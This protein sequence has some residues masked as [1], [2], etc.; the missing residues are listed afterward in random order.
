MAEKEEE[1]K[2][3]CPECG[4][5]VGTK[6]V[7]GKTKLKVHKVAGE[8]CEGSDTEVES[9]DTAPEGLAKGDPFDD[10]EDAQ[11]DEQSPN[12][13][14]DPETSPEPETGTQG[15]A[16]SAVPEFVHTVTVSHSCPYLD[17][18]AWHAENKKMAAKV[19]QQAGHVLAG[20]EAAHTATEPAGEFIHVRYTVLVK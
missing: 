20:G 18:Q 4:H 12:D 8:R 5:D 6:D 14:T 17:D 7:G 13:S 10:L 16:S 19:A 15:V 2:A 3:P 1:V 11:D 9:A